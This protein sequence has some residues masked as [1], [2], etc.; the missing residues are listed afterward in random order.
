MRVNNA[1]KIYGLI[2]AIVY[3]YLLSKYTIKNDSVAYSFEKKAK[4]KQGR[5]W[6]YP[7]FAIN[8]LL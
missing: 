2:S 4:N 5:A 8:F 6:S 3:T 1:S 7:R